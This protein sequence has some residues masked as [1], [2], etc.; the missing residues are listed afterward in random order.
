MDISKEDFF[1]VSSNLEIP[2]EKA[3]ALWIALENKNEGPSRVL[4]KVIY[5]LGALI[6]IG[7]MTWFMGLS[8][9]LFGGGGIF[10]IS[11]AYAFV[12]VFVG[13]L[14]W[15]KK[16]LRIPAGLLVTIAVCMVPL[17]IYGL[18]SYFEIWPKENP[19]HYQNFFSRIKDSWI[20]MEIGTVLAGL[21]A[22]RFFPFPF[23]TVPIFFSVWFFTMD[24]IP[25]LVGENPTW[26][27]MNWITLFFGLG[28]L[29]IG[30]LIDLYKK[31]EDYAFWCYLFGVLSFWGSLGAL[32]WEKSEAIMLLYCLIN[33]SM[34]LVS[35][36]LQRKIFMIFGSIGIFCYLSHLAYEVFE[37]SIWFPFVLS[38][39]GFGLIYAGFLYQKNAAWIENSILGKIPKSLQKYLP[40][41]HKDS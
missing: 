32:V 19:G 14:L 21:I 36:L 8:W 6:V 26:Q 11:S 27:Q 35:I 12:S 25:L 40:W 28:L 31:K 37:D 30:Y 22:L 34:L 17:A 4:S 1:S 16:D 41:P 29:A 24:V 38:F 2:K 18:E 3:E 5:Y 15:N 9:E 20:F 33:V 7:A 23:L 10:L 39:L 13:S